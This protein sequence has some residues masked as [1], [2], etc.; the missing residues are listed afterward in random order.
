VTEAA[1]LEAFARALRQEARNLLER[2]GLL[3]QQL[4]NRL[5][6]EA[7]PL[8]ET[9]DEELSRRR[10]AAAAGSGCDTLTRSLGRWCGP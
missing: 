7:E 3:W 2:P 1:T 6:W 4:Y 8:R 10:A 9:L 5:Q